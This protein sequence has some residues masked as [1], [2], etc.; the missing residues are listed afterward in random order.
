M[1]DKDRE[2]RFMTRQ[3]AYI[4]EIIDELHLVAHGE[5]PFGE[6]AQ[7]STGTVVRHMNM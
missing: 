6:I 7:E 2:P 4:E 5:G 1:I 3:V